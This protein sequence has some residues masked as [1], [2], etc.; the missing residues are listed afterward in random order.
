MKKIILVFF[1]AFA[2]FCFIRISLADYSDSSAGNVGL[3]YTENWEATE[4]FILKQDRKV[5]F[6]VNRTI[7][8]PSEAKLHYYRSTNPPQD[9]SN[10]GTTKEQVVYDFVPI[11]WRVTGSVNYQEK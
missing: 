8:G 4:Y 3:C 10:V 6:D 5:D 2:V 1:V 7:S 11:K 9:L